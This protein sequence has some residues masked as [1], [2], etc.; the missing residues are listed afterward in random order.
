MDQL[1][2]RYIYIYTYSLGYYLDLKALP[3]RKI[4]NST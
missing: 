3:L 4:S 2:G 1:T